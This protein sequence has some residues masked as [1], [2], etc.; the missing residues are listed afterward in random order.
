MR[1][2]NLR[3]DRARAFTLIELTV[4]IAIIAIM[5]GALLPVITQPYIQERRVE[6]AKEMGAIEE[7]IMGRPELGDY[8]YLGTVGRIPGPGNPA[9]PV[10]DLLAANGVGAPFVTLAGVPRGWQGPYLREA[11]LFPHLDPWG[12]AYAIITQAAPGN[13]VQWQ[14]RSNGPDTLP[15][16]G[17]DIVYPGGGNSFWNSVAQTFTITVMQTVAGV[18]TVAPDATP[19]TL[20]IAA[21]GAEQA[22]TI[23]V[24]G[25]AGQVTFTSIPGFIIPFGLHWVSFTIGVVSN[26]QVVALR[27]N[28]AYTVWK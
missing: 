8:G 28:S 15:N 9:V 20:H 25:G 19:V 6:V 13:Q 22:L 2:P 23:N 7:A 26:R 17:D 16:T 24:A 12:Q 3:H 18:P 14:I 5:A 1:R 11:T 4:V 21:G 27:P 10:L